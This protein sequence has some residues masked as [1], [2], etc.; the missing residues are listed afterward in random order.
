V[1]LEILHLTLRFLG[2]TA[3]ATL[4]R[5]RQAA[6]E[7]SSSWKRFD[8]R[9]SGLGCFPD[10]QRPRVIWA[11]AADDSG[12]LAV[13]AEDLERIARECGFPAEKR[14]FTGHLTIGR[15]KDRLSAEGGQRLGKVVL[16][17]QDESYGSV[18]VAAIELLKSDLR[19]DGPIYTR[20][21]T[22]DLTG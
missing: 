11:G 22:L 16:R 17:S 19:P 10:C 1:R 4:E 20:L 3:P 13:I 18:S 21:S 9:V 7:R 12:T 14:P 15:V 8:L 2:E 5:V 6:S